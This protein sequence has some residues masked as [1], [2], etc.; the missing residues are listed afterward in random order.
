MGKSTISMVIFNSYVKLPEGN[1]GG[2]CKLSPTTSSSKKKKTQKRDLRD[3]KRRSCL[4]N[5]LQRRGLSTANRNCFN[6]RVVIKFRVNN[7]VFNMSIS[8]LM[9]KNFSPV[10]PIPNRL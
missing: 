5:W 9:K 10:L 7:G 3:A 1:L 8:D 2:S 6:I 4:P